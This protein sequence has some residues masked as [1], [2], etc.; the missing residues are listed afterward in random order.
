MLGVQGGTKVAG[1]KLDALLE[2]DVPITGLW[3]QDWV[4]Q[5]KTDFCKQLWWNWELDEDHYANWDTFKQALDEKDIKVLGYVNPFVVDTSEKENVKMSLYNV[6]KE[7]DF[8]IKDENG[9]IG[10]ASGREARYSGGG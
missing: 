10:R 9:E 6:A 5:R 7:K 3:I 4:G 1:K 8:L 2:H